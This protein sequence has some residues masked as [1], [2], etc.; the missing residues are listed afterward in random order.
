[1]EA[2]GWKPAS[3]LEPGDV[4]QT[5]EGTATL[6]AREKLEGEHPVYN[7][8]VAGT[9]TYFV[10][11]GG[12]WVHNSCGKLDELVKKFNDHLYPSNKLAEIS[13]WWAK[14]WPTNGNYLE[15]FFG[16]GR[17]FERLMRQSKFNTWKWTGDISS[18]FP[19]IDFY[20]VIGGKN[21]VA[22]LKTSNMTPAAW[23]A[24]PKNKD[25]LKA[26]VD[27]FNKKQFAQGFQKIVKA[28]E[29]RLVI[30]VPQGRLSEFANFESSVHALNSQIPGINKIKVEITTIENALSL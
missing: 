16:R 12:L 27:G 29:V 17:F 14:G 19:G 9:H 23:L 30:A 4:L 2:N 21:V 20:K 28:D 3:W 13:E 15:S 8:T 24:T 5:K 26:L 18:N 11:E 25:H 7:I 1:M 22:S 6:L 10:G